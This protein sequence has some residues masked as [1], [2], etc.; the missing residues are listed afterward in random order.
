MGLVGILLAFMLGTAN[1][2][3]DTF[4]ATATVTATRTATPTSTVTPTAPLC[5]GGYVTVGSSLDDAANAQSNM[6]CVVSRRHSDFIY[7]TGNGAFSTMPSSGAVV[8]W[9]L[10]YAVPAVACSNRIYVFKIWR[11]TAVNTYRCIGSDFKFTNLDGQPTTGTLVFEIPI[12]IAVVTGDFIG[13]D[14][15]ERLPG[16][17]CAEKYFFGS[18]GT[19]GGACAIRADACPSTLRMPAVASGILLNCD[20]CQVPLSSTPTSTSTRTFTST[21]TRTATGTLTLTPTVTPTSTSSATRTATATRTAS[22]TRTGTATRTATVTA[23]ATATATVTSTGTQTATATIT[24]T[25]TT[26]ATD[27]PTATPTT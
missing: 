6:G 19:T 9:R 10:K 17:P 1:A 20:L 16:D 14:L 2:A 15:D 13:V 8:R 24:A 3:T 26:T 27:T 11:Q 7:L 4:T 5:A 25:D 12:P 22:A 23:T 18:F 21:A